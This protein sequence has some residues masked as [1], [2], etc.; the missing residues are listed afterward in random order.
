[1]GKH[2][3]EN[4]LITESAAERV[5]LDNLFNFYVSKF[6]DTV[7]EVEHHF[8]IALGSLVERNELDIIVVQDFLD[9]MGIEGKIPK[10]EIAVSYS[11]GD[12]CG[13]STSRSSC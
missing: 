4:K 3:E 9:E 13:R 12:G 8:L 2:Q 5:L 10:K 11:S 7:A 6:P 1:M